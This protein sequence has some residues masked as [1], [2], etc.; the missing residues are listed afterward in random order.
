M[1][2]KR[3]AVLSALSLLVL[4][5]RAV[6][7]QGSSIWDA[8]SDESRYFQKKTTTT[9]ADIKKRYGRKQ[10]KKSTFKRQVYK[11]P[12]PEEIATQAFY[13]AQENF[14]AAL[15]K[16]AYDVRFEK[17]DY[18][19]PSDTLVLTNLTVTPKNAGSSGASV[20]YIMKAETVEVM[21]FN[22]GE[23]AGTPM[24]E[25][26]Q[27]VISKIDLPVYNEKNVKV[28]KM[29]LERLDIRG[30]FMKALPEGGGKF[31]LVN[32][33]GF[34]L[35]KIINET[36]LN[37][38]VRSKIFSANQ[39][40]F[41]DVTVPAGFIDALKNQTLGGF[42]F[43]EASINNERV[44]STAGAEAALTSYSA[45]VLNPDLVLGARME[46]QKKQPVVSLSRIKENAERNKK[47]R[48]ALDSEKEQLNAER[49]AS[50]KDPDA[51]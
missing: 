16:G 21:G 22:L 51:R 28:G 46:A 14:R 47:E 27:T 29:E 48:A 18:N 41:S 3:I 43:R 6:A 30:P 10:A 15:P 9:G 1:N 32:L 37:N 25:D 39:A 35:E 4:S 13:K 24:R 11:G 45:R 31:G 33:T 17:L 26:G 5:S 23:K 42:A 34:K 7:Q 20:P 8:P 49:E 40:S 19:V 44:T 2:V 50:D 36:V 38:I 12:T